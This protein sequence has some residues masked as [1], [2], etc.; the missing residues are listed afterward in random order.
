M[1]CVIASR[2]AADHPLG[3]GLFNY[4]AAYDRY[5]TSGGKYGHK[6]AVHSSHFQVLAE[7]GYPG[8]CVWVGCFV[9]AMILVFR[10]RIRARDPNRPE[11]SRRL[12]LNTANSLLV[13]MIGF[14]IGGSFIAGALNDF[15]WLVF[16]MVAALDRLSGLPV[17]ATTIAAEAAARPE[18]TRAA[19][20]RF[21]GAY[22]RRPAG[23]AIAGTAP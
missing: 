21:R 15:T 18:T 5:D 4:E 12:L 1:I 17:K 23:R 20:P 9:V 8:L 2:I 19:V 10:A 6:R 13:S 14:L 16:G 7:Q 3:I 11:A 22:R